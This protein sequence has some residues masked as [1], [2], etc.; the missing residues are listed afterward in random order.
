MLKMRSAGPLWDRQATPPVRVKFIGFNIPLEELRRFSDPDGDWIRVKAH[1]PLAPAPIEGDVLASDVVSDKAERKDF[2]I[3]SFL[4]YCTLV[5]R[6]INEGAGGAL[7]LGIN[8]DY[9]IALAL[10]VNRVTAV[11][12]G[13]QPW[14]RS[15][16]PFKINEIEW[17]TFLAQGNNKD[18]FFPGDRLDPLAQA[19]AEA[20][21]TIQNTKIIS[22]ALTEQGKGSGP[23]IPNSI[24]LFIVRLIGPQAGVNALKHVGG[25]TAIDAVIAGAGGDIDALK[26]RYPEF[27]NVSGVSTVSALLTLIEERFDAALKLAAILLHDYTPEDLPLVPVVGEAPWFTAAKA[28]E[29]VDEIN[30]AAR[31]MQYF[32]STTFHATSAKDPWCAAFVTFCMKNCGNSIVA[33][34]VIARNNAQA[35]AWKTWGRPLS[36]GSEALPPG[37][38]VVLSPVEGSDRSG[39]VSFFARRNGKQVVLFGGNQNNC[40]QES[41]Y[42]ASRIAAVRWIDWSGV[43]EAAEKEVQGGTLIGGTHIDDLGNGFPPLSGADWKKYCH[44]LGVRESNNRYE[45]VNKLGFCGRWQF[46]ALALIDTGYVKPGRTKNSSLLS[47][48]SWTG[49]NGVNSR[50][51]WLSNWA[52]QNEAMHAYT[53]MHYK[54]LLKLG[55]LKAGSSLPRIVGLLAAAH[56][57]GVGGAMKL[58]RGTST[59]DAFGTKTGDYYAYLSNEFGGSQTLQA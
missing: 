26:A 6:I 22:D 20:F 50:D 34:S 2:N 31:V 39:H 29:G 44:T 13:G 59:S 9:L 52:A 28:E 51:D 43:T 1:F 48:T 45:V 23:Y 8:R 3:W 12:Q 32:Q 36:I 58:V 35:A 54:H 42:P 47:S 49:K 38:V 30:D 18:E 5:A 7:E 15:F 41:S 40:V 56:L 53:K 21:S 4:K 16:N 19:D 10:V 24:D 25:A 57:M 33:A 46:G 14:D 17:S 37:A 11:P 55:G 27:L